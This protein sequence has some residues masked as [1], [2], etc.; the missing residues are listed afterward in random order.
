MKVEKTSTLIE[1]G[2]LTTAEKSTRAQ[3]LPVQMA[4]CFQKQNKT[5][6][7]DALISSATARFF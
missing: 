5:P 1:T 4:K 6:G 7:L 3:I 2:H